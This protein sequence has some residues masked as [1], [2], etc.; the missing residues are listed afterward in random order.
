MLEGGGGQG[1]VIGG[2]DE[3]EGKKEDGKGGRELKKK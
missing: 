2:A 1:S 3:R